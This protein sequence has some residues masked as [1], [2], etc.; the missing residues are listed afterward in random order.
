M[1]DRSAWAARFAR[2][3]PFFRS[4]RFGVLL[5]VLAVLVMPPFF[6]FVWSMMERDI[7]GAIRANVAA[8]ATESIAAFS[9]PG[10]PMAPFADRPRSAP[11]KTAPAAAPRATEPSGMDSH[12]DS[13]ALRHVL[14]IRV[15]EASGRIVAD[16]DRDQGTDLVHQIGMLFLGADGAPTLEG[17]DR[18]LEPVHERSEFVTARWDEPLVGCRWS[19]GGKLLVCH[20]VQRVR[21]P[22]GTDG[23][24]YVQESSR[25]AVRALYDL[26]FQ[27]ARLT[28]VILPIALVLAWWMGTRFVRPI[29]ALRREAISKAGSTNPTGALSTRGK[30]EV[31]DLAQAFN[32]LLDKLEERRGTNERFVADLVHEFKNPVAAVRA[33]GE[34][35]SGGGV[36]G[37]RAARLSRVL[38]DS[39]GRLDTL[40]TQFLELAR[41]EAGMPSEPRTRIELVDT[42]QGVVE[43]MRLRQP[44]VMFDVVA[45]QA[46]A[47]MGVGSRLDS[48][49]RNL[50]ENAAAFA[51]CGTTG[52]P[53]VSVSVLRL[54]DTVEVHV[55]DNGPGIAAE[56]LPRVFERFFTTRGRERGSGLGLALVKA[57][58]EAHQ[59]HVDVKSEAGAGATFV[60]Q[61]VAAE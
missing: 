55:S 35:L 6:V 16:A 1:T 15:L 12:L 46:V 22:D 45:T 49:L 24:V 3:T 61:L 31:R 59:G 9:A 32:T 30:D 42:V 44:D 52:A 58:V 4:L 39:S 48:V 29:E 26:R 54:R 14:R 18:S 2:R 43:A 21:L 5:V 8:A 53:R 60:I 13:I 41:A 34:S 47:V 27:L 36:D 57:V 20:A 19:P 56:D 28:V 37:Q 7:E 33:C 25:R 51:S 10:E 23:I 11:I 17:F 40:V 38:L 50:L